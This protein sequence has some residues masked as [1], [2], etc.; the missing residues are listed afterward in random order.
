MTSQQP[1]TSAIRALAME[2][3]SLQ[4][5]PV[6][7]FTVKLINE[8]LFEW[9]VAIFGPPSTLYEGAYFKVSYLHLYIRFLNS[10]ARV[11]LCASN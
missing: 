10:T 2:F 1:S 7:G 8:D 9:Q 11:S 6:E 4:E 3:K 5:E